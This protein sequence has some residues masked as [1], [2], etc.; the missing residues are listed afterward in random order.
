MPSNATDDDAGAAIGNA[1]A[2]LSM[3]VNYYEGPAAIQGF[4]DDLA[5]G[6]VNPAIIWIAGDEADNDIDSTEGPVINANGDKIAAFAYGGGGLMAHGAG[7]NAFGWLPELLP[8]AREVEI[9]QDRG[10]SLTPAGTAFLPGVTYEELNDGPWHGFFEGDFT[11]LEVLGD[12][13]NFLGLD[14]QP[15]AVIIGGLAVNNAPTRATFAVKKVFSDDATTPVQVQIDCNTGAIPDHIKTVTPDDSEEFEI[16]WIITDFDAGE[17]DCTVSE[18]PVPGYTTLYFDDIANANELVNDGTSDSDEGGCH[19]RNMF[20]G[21]ESTCVVYNELEEVDVAI[22]KV[23]FDEH[24]E[25]NNSLWARV[26]WEC[27]YARDRISEDLPFGSVYTNPSTFTED[28]YLWFPDSDFT[29]ENGYTRTRS[30][31]VYPN[32]NPDQQTV[33]EAY[34]RIKDSS[35]ESDDASCDELKLAPGAGAECTIVNTRIYEGIPTLSQYGL[36]L[37]ALMM[38]TVGLMAGRRTI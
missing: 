23:W 20:G 26:H 17:L 3:T 30:F 28:D 32:W 24:P 9:D 12:A 13:D 33:C 5:G 1:A 14:G 4:F 27:R 19:F 34:E 22:T 21:E 11:P 16:K 15:V 2:D 25:F 6:T 7:P 10:V 18:L 29:A 38:L 8:G 37:L 36:A 31:S 35:V